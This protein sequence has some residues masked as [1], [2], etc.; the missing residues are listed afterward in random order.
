MET[1]QNAGRVTDRALELLEHYHSAEGKQ[2]LYSEL[3]KGNGG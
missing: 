2:A 3:F 1:C